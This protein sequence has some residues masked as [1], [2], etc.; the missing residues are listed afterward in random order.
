MKILTMN[1][2]Y[3]NGTR[4]VQYDNGMVEKQTLFIKNGK[5]T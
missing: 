5:P 3:I 4:I 1:G 2:D